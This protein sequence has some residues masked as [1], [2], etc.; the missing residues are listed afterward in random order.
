MMRQFETFKINGVLTLFIVDSTKYDFYV[1]FRR[2][3]K[4]LEN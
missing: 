3:I 4:Q 1:G 2:V